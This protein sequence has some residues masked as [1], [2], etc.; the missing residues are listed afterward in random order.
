MPGFEPKEFPP[1]TVDYSLEIGEEEISALAFPINL[2][3]KSTFLLGSARDLDGT[4]QSMFDIAEEIASVEV[5][6]YIPFDPETDR[7]KIAAKRNLSVTDA[8]DPSS[9]LLYIAHAARHFGKILHAEAGA[10]P[11]LRA[12]CEPWGAGSLVCYPLHR[13]RDMIGALVFGKRNGNTFSQ[14]LVKL[15]WVLAHHAESLLAQSEAVQEL[16]FYSFLD[17]L[18]HLYNRRFFDQQLEKEILRSRRNGNPFSLL[19]LDLDGF[20]E[21]N[22]RFLHQAGDIALQE[23]ATILSD[24]VREVDTVARI[25]G[26]EF[27]VILVESNAE[28]VRDLCRR[29]LD[30]IGKHLLPG[31][32]GVRTER[33]TASVGVASFPSDSFDKQDLLAK[34]DRALYM[35]KSQGGGKLCLFHEISDLLSAQAA[36]GDLP[37]Q[38]VYDAARSVVDMDK[39]LEILLFT[40]MQGLSATRGSIVVLDPKGRI[41]IR[42]AVGFNNGE[43]HLLAGASVTPG[44]ITSWVLAHR[45]PLV[46]SDQED[47]PI[48]VRW[49][50]NGYRSESFLS[51]PLLLGDRLLGA[52]H[53]TNRKEGRPFTREDLSAFEPI[54]AEIAKVLNQGM[55]FRENVRTFSTSILVSLAHAL[56]LRYPFLQGHFGRVAELSLRIGGELGLSDDDLNVLKTAAT[57]HDIGMVGLPGAI[58][59]KARRLSDRELEIARKHPFLGAKLLEGV[60]GAEA[61]RR[62]ILEHQEFW[63]GSGY[64]HGLR[65]EEISLPGRILSLAEYYDSIRSERPHRGGLRHEEAAQ[66]I[67]S[68]VGKL[69]DEKVCESFFRI[70]LPAG[71]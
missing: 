33:L 50:R 25:G 42:T 9:P 59:S 4:F 47:L 49:K 3:L 34:S 16:S 20:K 1:C 2:L 52:L 22:D 17:P 19:M 21:Y 7:F 64:P 60:P 31:V 65:G 63:D 29:I 32:E 18:T 14:G 38:K 46:A 67:R 24:S 37:V 56:E 13:N 28:A 36:P 62:V 11:K 23:Y 71:S 30:R 8:A 69:F 5:C 58:F 48:A 26:D 43:N 45:K 61:V 68:N 39:F 27:A 70:D 53:L 15:L 51:I 54:A 57:L 41:S 40:A 55:E 10:D 44:E 66:I 35:A 6:G 12:L